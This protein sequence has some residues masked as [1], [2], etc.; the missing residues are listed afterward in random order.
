MANRFWVGGTGNWSDTAHWSAT[1]GG[2]GGSSV[3]TSADNVYFD[4]L[5]FSATGQTVTVDVL[6]NCLDMDW[7]GALKNPTFAGT[8]NLNVYG[9]LTTIA[10]MQ[11]TFSGGLFFTA[12][13]TGKTITTNGLIFTTSLI[14]NTVAGGWTLQDN[15]TTTVAFTFNAGNLNTNG[16]SVSCVNFSSSGSN[17]RTLTLGSSTITISGTLNF[18]TTTNFTFSAGSSTIIISGNT[19]IFSGGGLTYNN[20]ELQGTPI[21]ITGSNTFNTLTLTAGKTVNLTSGT[22]QTVTS[23]VCNGTT[24]SPSTLKSVTAGSAATIALPA[25]RYFIRHTS[26]KDI[27]VTG[28]TAVTSIAGTNV[29]GNTGITFVTKF[30]MGRIKNDGSFNWYSTTTGT[31][32]KVSG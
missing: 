6:A 26:I 27:T 32:T 28:A 2:A 24:A 16:K 11:T 15:V 19:V 14:F 12:A 18:A 13:S 4:A 1:S 20:V 22:T 30:E 3:P 8:F 9:S 7:T 10:A 5:S 23:L 25:G 31:V 17:V 21:T 29:S